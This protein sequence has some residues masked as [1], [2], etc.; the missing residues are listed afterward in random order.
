M[1][2]L[3]DKNK[4]IER[5]EKRLDST[6]LLGAPCR[7]RSCGKGGRQRKLSAAD[8][9]IT[10]GA[11]LP[12]YCAEQI[13]SQPVAAVQV[14]A[15]SEEPEDG[16]G[17]V[18]V[19]DEAVVAST[20]PVDP[21]DTTAATT[22]IRAH[23]LDTSEERHHPVC[24]PEVDGVKSPDGS[25]R[26][27]ADATTT[28]ECKGKKGQQR[29]YTASMEPKVVDVGADRTDD[30][31]KVTHSGVP[32]GMAD[33][34][35]GMFDMPML[36]L[37]GPSHSSTPGQVCV[38]T[39][40]ECSEAAKESHDE[41]GSERRKGKVVKR[42]WTARRS[43]RGRRRPKK[44]K[45]P[46]GPP[47]KEEGLY[48][49][50]VGLQE[51]VK[52]Q[53]E[54]TEN[55]R[56]VDEAMMDAGSHTEH[57]SG[58]A[59]LMADFQLSDG[60][61]DE[62]GESPVDGSGTTPSGDLPVQEE[63]KVCGSDSEGDIDSGRATGSAAPSVISEGGPSPSVAECEI[64]MEIETNDCHRVVH[65]D[66]RLGC[67]PD[68]YNSE[69]AIPTDYE[70]S[71]Q[72]DAELLLSNKREENA[73]SIEQSSDLSVPHSPSPPHHQC[74]RYSLEEIFTNM[75][76]LGRLSPIPTDPPNSGLEWSKEDDGKTNVS[77]PC[78][79]GSD[80]M[81]V[82]GRPS[83]LCK[84]SYPRLPQSSCSSIDCAQDDNASKQSD[85]SPS[86]L[87]HSPK[88]KDISAQQ[89]RQAMKKKSAPSP[90]LSSQP[91]ARQ[92]TLLPAKH[93]SA[94]AVLPLL[95]SA[96]R[97][98]TRD[99]LLS[100]CSRGSPS[101]PVPLLSDPHSGRDRRKGKAGVRKSM[102]LKGISAPLVGKGQPLIE[103]E[104]EK[105]SVAVEKCRDE[106]SGA[107]VV[108]LL[109]SGG[110]KDNPPQNVRGRCSPLESE[111]GKEQPVAP[112]ATEEPLCSVS[113]YL[114]DEEDGKVS[115]PT[116]LNAST[117]VA[118]P[119][120][121]AVAGGAACRDLGPVDSSEQGATST[122]DTSASIEIGADEASSSN[123]G[124]AAGPKGVEVIG[125]LES[126]GSNEMAGE[127]EEE[128][129]DGEVGSSDDED[130][131]PVCDQVYASCGSSDEAT[132]GMTTRS[133]QVRGEGGSKGPPPQAVEGI[134]SKRTATPRSL[135]AC[136]TLL[137]PSAKKQKLSELPIESE[138][139]TC[140]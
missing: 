100:S 26:E 86:V 30:T 22:D 18:D 109:Q 105:S 125:V 9:G 94:V 119:S 21:R 95:P 74:S 136:T 73:P 28:E 58:M 42:K 114:C 19:L 137:G 81:D 69:D 127:E 131:S 126:S 17:F 115:P 63:V 43:K 45:A 139:N 111:V 89:P 5:L 116:S 90:V 47:T 84:E 66:S 120:T 34:P 52:G 93:P 118:A 72:S 32:S 31:S 11:S 107:V 124:L 87:L 51:V 50:N 3:L 88:S 132:R 135:E 23:L 123:G 140:V 35:E 103:C 15:S 130:P 29:R 46:Q 122:A 62:E 57:C 102:V 112:L 48:Q 77:L 101:Q 16:E 76:P 2:R 82:T 133:S 75:L 55:H 92:C 85:V 68:E 24:L 8:S 10:E 91:R 134:G 117:L 97:L 98:R 67:N 99:I 108:S 1:C 54:M 110:G 80:Q 71:Q 13:P 64:A 59:A 49:E 104:V 6:K 7:A 65:S 14:G 33:A 96:T 37:D 106:E 128:M 44:T 25:L 4:K 70:D 61:S 20:P 53:K 38:A 39:D 83:H 121:S 129:E 113:E 60:S 36:A 41:R 79:S 40:D 56:K 12:Q 27:H 138:L 78:S